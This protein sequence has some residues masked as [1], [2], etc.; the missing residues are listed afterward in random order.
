MI[1]FLSMFSLGGLFLLISP[2]LR[3]SVQ[4]GIGA[5]YMEVQIYAPFSYVGLGIL[6]IFV[7][8]MMFR[9]GARAR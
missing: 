3:G 6:L 8:I 1:R 7:V 5:V 2:K 4:D 9:S